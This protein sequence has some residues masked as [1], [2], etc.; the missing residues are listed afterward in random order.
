MKKYLLLIAAVFTLSGCVNS[1]PNEED[2]TRAHTLVYAKECTNITINSVR[3]ISGQHNPTD[4]SSYVAE[5]E[6]SIRLLDIAAL[7]VAAETWKK[8]QAVFA[9]SM[10]VAATF[11]AVE[12]KLKNEYEQ[13]ITKH[14]KG[15][16]PYDS[17]KAKYDDALG[18][19]HEKHN[20]LRSELDLL[21][22]KVRN[23][24]VF[25]HEEEA[26]RKIYFKGC[27]NSGIMMYDRVLNYPRQ[28]VRESGDP[29]QWFK[30]YDMKFHSI[31]PMRKGNIGWVINMPVF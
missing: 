28:V 18:N 29:M 15:S 8:E 25:A 6:Y 9:E 22:D 1:V 17:W 26:V 3:K 5:Y 31:H 14:P 19:I 27:S 13:F 16:E 11:D 12:L 23:F 20:A 24:K 21:I 7:A 30:Y 4:S 2:I 10:Q